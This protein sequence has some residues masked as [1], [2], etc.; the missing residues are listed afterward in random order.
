M[1]AKRQAEGV[2]LRLDDIMGKTVTILDAEFKTGNFGPYAV[3]AVDVGDG[4]TQHIMTS[5][6]LVLDALENAA[7]ENAF[8]VDATFKKRGRVWI[9]E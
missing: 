6:M 4:E 2:P 5:A 8:P 9:V 7:A 1:F 3:M